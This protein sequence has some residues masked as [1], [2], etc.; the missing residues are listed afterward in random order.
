VLETGTVLKLFGDDSGE[1]DEEISL[2][3]CVVVAGG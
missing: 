2:V 1:R 3:C